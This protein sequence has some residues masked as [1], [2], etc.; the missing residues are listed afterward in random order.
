MRTAGIIYI[1]ARRIFYLVS[2]FERVARKAVSNGK[3]EVVRIIFFGI[4]VRNEREFYI[5]F[6]LF[7]KRIFAYLSE[8]VL[9]HRILFPFR[10]KRAV[11]ARREKNRSVTSPFAVVVLPESF[12]AVFDKTGHLRAERAYGKFYRSVVY[13]VKHIFI[14]FAFGRVARAAGFRADKAAVSFK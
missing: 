3:N 12:L 4:L 6:A 14:S 13:F 5:I 7:F 1:A 2:Y 9:Y 11:P 8:A 10:R